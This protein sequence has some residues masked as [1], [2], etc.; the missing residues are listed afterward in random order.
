MKTPKSQKISLVKNSLYSIGLYATILLMQIYTFIKNSLPVSSTP[1]FIGPIY[2]PLLISCIM[3]LLLVSVAI[4]RSKQSRN[5]EATDELAD[6]HK[7]KAGYFTKYITVFTIPVIIL[8]MKECNWM[9]KEDL[10]GNV[11]SAI[12]ISISITEIIHNV[13]FIILDKK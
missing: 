1:I 9:P 6:L 7:Y 5:T 12:L 10:V 8:L 4:L 2:L 11:L 3:L 13:I